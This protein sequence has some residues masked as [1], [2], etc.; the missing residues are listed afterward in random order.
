MPET[1]LSPSNLLLFG[2][3]VVDLEIKHDKGHDP[4]PKVENCHKRERIGCALDKA[5]DDKKKNFCKPCFARIYGFSYGN[6]YYDLPGATLFLVHGEGTLVTEIPD[7][8]FPSRAPRGPDTIGL[9]ETD[10]SFSNDIYVWSYDKIDFTIRMD[11]ETGLFEDVLLGAMLDGGM[12]ASGMNAR[13]M[14]AR[15]MN[16][17]GMNARGMNARGMNARGGNSD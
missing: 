6:F 12:D 17:R 16:A 5:A 14:N 13:G 4:S 1:L 11:V 8:V 15:G 10:F 2:R 9:G 3:V 7:N